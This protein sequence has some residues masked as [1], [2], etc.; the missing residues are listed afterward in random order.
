MSRSMSTYGAKGCWSFFFFF[1][2]PSFLYDDNENRMYNT[3]SI[4]I[5]SQPS[6]QAPISVLNL[7]SRH[8]GFQLHARRGLFWRSLLQPNFATLCPDSTIGRDRVLPY[9]NRFPGRAF[10]SCPWRR[11]GLCLDKTLLFWSGTLAYR[12]NMRIHGYRPCANVF[13]FFFFCFGHLSRP[14]LSAL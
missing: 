3:S 7:I 1:F 10:C 13:F 14:F 2:S 11:G 9:G 5:K 4:F 12:S 6:H 8:W